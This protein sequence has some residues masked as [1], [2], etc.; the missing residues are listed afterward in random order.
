MLAIG[1][2][3]LWASLRAGETEAMSDVRSVT[4]V[5]ARTVVQPNLSPELLAGDPDAL[6]QLDAI[7]RDRVLDDKAL[8]VKLWDTDGRIVYSDESRLIGEVYTFDEEKRSAFWT[9]EIVSEIS[10]LTGPENRFETE[11][12]QMLEVYLPIDGPD[13]EPLLYESYFDISSVDA[14]ADRIRSAFFPI[15]AAALVLMEAMHLALAWVMGRR[16][17][18][19]QAERELFFQRAMDASQLERRRIAA[20]LHGGVVQELVATSTAVAAAAEGADREGRESADELKVVAVGA[21]RSLRSLRTL[22]VDLYPPSIQDQ[23]LESALTDLLA[24]AEGLGIQTRLKVINVADDRI[25]TSALVYRVVQESVRN[26]LRHAHA[27]NIE[28]F[29]E[30]V[31]SEDKAARRSTV[32]TIRDDGQGFDPNE[33]SDVGNVSLRLLADIT[34]DAG[35]DLSISNTPGAGTVVRLEVPA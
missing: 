5:V 1:G 26:I 10:S 16:L 3:S 30:G 21:R 32:A 9:A 33:P 19:A 34:A 25:E 31:R 24:P 17:R 12:E 15:V 27:S 6:A 4:G 28:V 2:G 18:K 20:E 7:V 13:G 11:R 29:V 8:R 22:L 14:S 23:G 35:A